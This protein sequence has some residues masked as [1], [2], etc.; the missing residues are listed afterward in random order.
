MVSQLPILSIVVPCYNEEEVLPE[1]ARRL[2]TILDGLVDEGR[3]HEDSRIYFI[4]DGSED[5]TWMLIEELNLSGCRFEG[6]KL[7]RNRGHQNALIAGLLVVPGDLI[8]SV[9]ADLQDDLNAIQYMLQENSNGAEIVFGVRGG[10]KLDTYF[11][12]ATAQFYYRFL[13][14]MGVEVIYNHA[15]YRLMSRRAV[16]ALR[17]YQETNLFLRAIIPELGFQTAIVT[18][19]R[20]KRFAGRSKYSLRKMLS[21]AFEGI[22][23]FS[24]QPLRAIALLGFFVSAASFLLSIWAFLIAV[25]LGRTVPGWASTVVPIYMICGVQLLCLGIVGEYIGKI[26]NE[27]KR[28]PRFIIDKTTM[29]KSHDRQV[30]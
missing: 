12:R 13:K 22:T 17:Q 25:G 11:K 21:F 26:Y 27:T 1:T 5:R 2:R 30:S 15:D 6:I 24:T 28:R 14:W 9:D 8:L 29:Q 18:F 10:R 7:T 3:L 23:S 4:D 19:E 20:G 16:E